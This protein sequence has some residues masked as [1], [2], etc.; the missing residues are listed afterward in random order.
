M[1]RRTPGH[2]VIGLC[3][4]I[5]MALLTAC[6]G[7]GT[8]DLSPGR[9]HPTGPRVLCVVA[10]PDDEVAFSGTLYKITT[11]LGGACDIVVITNGE[12]G[13]KYSTLAEV[14][15]RRRLTDP[16]TGRSELP[17][18]RQQEM[19]EAARILGVRHVVF[20]SEQD[21][22]YTTDPNEVLGPGTDVW[23]LERIRAELSRV[24]RE[25]RYDF[26]FVHLPTPTTHGHHQAASILALEA[27]AAMEFDQRPVPLGSFWLRIPAESEE[28]TDEEEEATKRPF[29]L[30]GFP[31][32]RQREDVLPFTFDTRQTFGFEDKLD[33]RIVKS[34]AVAAHK[35]QG[36]YQQLLGRGDMEAFRLFALPVEAAESRAREL[37][38]RLAEPQ[39]APVHYDEQGEVLTTPAK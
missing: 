5:L 22:R 15:Y 36:R 23:N 7:M 9:G 16:T 12:A 32:T 10:H 17:A 13:Y 29:E 2:S 24:L 26:L 4:L 27:V 39:F 8:A 11:H 1:D 14:I 25:G 30:P 38:R 31:I 19:R 6:Q 34:W 37:F 21:H 35:S 3:T 33:Y 18:I 20:L 28:P